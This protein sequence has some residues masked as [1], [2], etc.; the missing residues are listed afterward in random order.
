MPRY[1]FQVAYTLPDGTVAYEPHAVDAATEA[2]AMAAVDAVTQRYPNAVGATKAI[3]LV[4]A[5]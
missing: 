2:E 5:V 3:T 1:L 4:L